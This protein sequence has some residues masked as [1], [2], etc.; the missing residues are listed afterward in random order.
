MLDRATGGAGALLATGDATMNP[1]W[2]AD[3]AFLAY[4]CLR[5]GHSDLWVARA[6]GTD[7]RQVTRDPA[8]DVHPVWHPGGRNLFFVS[9]RNAETSCTGSTSPTEPLNR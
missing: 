7:P 2:S 5:D 4:A 1:A 8:N 6:D 3:G 9:D